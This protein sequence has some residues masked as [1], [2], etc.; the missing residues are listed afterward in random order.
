[1][2]SEQFYHD[3]VAKLLLDDPRYS[4]DAYH[5]VRDTV[6]F[7]AHQ[8]Q[9]DA[10]RS[11]HISGEELLECMRLFALQQYGPMAHTVL[12]TWGIR[13]TDDFGN[14]VFA[15]IGQKLL[16]A[17]KDDAIEHF[18]DGFDFGEA[19]DRPFIPDGDGEPFNLP[20]LDA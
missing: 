4:E 16:R 11:Q 12:S 17:S 14:I 10:G 15:M 13:K 6:E 5:F 2:S 18:Q 19:F 9:R 8:L 7:A 1:M 3:S 20:Q